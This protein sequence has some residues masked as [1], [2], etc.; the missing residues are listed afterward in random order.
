MVGYGKFVFATTL[1]GSLARSADHFITANVLNVI[2]PAAVSYYNAANRV[3]SMLDA[4]TTAAADIL[5]PKNAQAGNET[6]GLN[7]VKYYFEKMVATLTLV[8]IPMV[9][10]IV[11]FPKFILLISGGAKYVEAVPILQLGATYALLRPFIYN[12]GH[13]IDAIGKPHV[14]FWANVVIM[15]SNFAMTWFFLN[16]FGL[17]GAAYGT[18]G[19]HIL[20]TLIFY[21]LLKKHL[22]ISVKNILFYMK[23]TLCSIT[24]KMRSKRTMNED[25]R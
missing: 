22:H 7:K 4:P 25:P 12:F 15:L 16:Q 13:T 2:N 14:N 18:F 3:T 9:L 23:E 11:V 21:F 6:D 20:Y 19:M 10:V 24:N 1:F 17:M 8:M 5:F